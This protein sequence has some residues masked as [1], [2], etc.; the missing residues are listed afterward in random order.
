MNPEIGRFLTTDPFPGLMHEP[1]TLHKYLYAGLNP[2]SNVDPSGKFFGGFSFGGFFLN[3]SIGLR[4][5]ASSALFYGAP[6]LYLAQR[7]LLRVNVAFL[8]RFV[9]LATAR[10]YQSSQ[11]VLIN[12]GRILRLDAGRA[13]ESLLR[14]AMRLIPGS[15]YHA[16]IAG[17][18]PD[19]IIRGRHIVDAKLGQALNF[20]QLGRFVDFASSRGGN[21]I[22]ITLTR[23]PPDV[24]ARA[25][26]LGQAQGVVVNFIALTPF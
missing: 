2:V 19:W 10:F 17:A 4:L 1:V 15:Q 11:S 13:F 12:S 6:L 18:I 24:V 5:Y 26:A 14:P 3:V 21:V 22:Y 8:A 9:N 20:G 7:V 25:R 16:R 23:T